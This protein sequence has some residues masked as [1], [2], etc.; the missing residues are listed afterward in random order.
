M[1]LIDLTKVRQVHK[2]TVAAAKAPFL[3]LG[4]LGIKIRQKQS[5]GDTSRPALPWRGTRKI[6]EERLDK[7]ELFQDL[8][9][10][11]SMKAPSLE[12]PAQDEY[13]V[14]DDAIKIMRSHVSGGAA[15]GLYNDLS[16]MGRGRAETGDL[17]ALRKLYESLDNNRISLSPE[18]EDTL[19]MA[20]QLSVRLEDLKMH[21]RTVV[22][23]VQT[24]AAIHA[25]IDR[26]DDAPLITATFKKL[27]IL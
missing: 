2:G 16:E 19:E 26:S 23:Y 1:K 5:T 7:H 20:H 18:Y 15:L 22:S 9:F 12:L 11:L 24:L 25:K 14:L 6:N 8:L 27:G 17:Y 3:D 21:C 4:V 13:A 10:S